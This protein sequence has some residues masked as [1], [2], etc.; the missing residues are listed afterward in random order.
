MK[1]YFLG[2]KA[3]YEKAM[4]DSLSASFTVAE[5]KEPSY[6]RRIYSLI[7]SV[8]KRIPIGMPLD[9]LGRRVND[10]L[11]DAPDDILI[12]N[13]WAL[14]RGVNTGIARTFK[15]RRVLLI[16]DL[17]ER[18][19]VDSVR[20]IFDSIYSF[21]PE[22]CRALDISHL[23][24]FFPFGEEAAHAMSGEAPHARSGAICN[25]LGRDKGRGS[26]LVEI[27][28]ALESQG[29]QLDFQ[30]VRDRTTQVESKYHVAKGRSYAQSLKM[31][32]AADVL[33]DVNQPGQ[34]GFTLRVLEAL[35]FDRKLLTTNGAV[36]QAPF[37]DPAR[38]FVWGE[39]SPQDLPRFLGGV[40]A[41]VS[42]D[43]LYR[44]S[45]EAMMRCV[46]SNL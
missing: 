40:P 13:A 14:P 27:A 44:H 18:S 17:S 12:C 32:F 21:D 39:D 43:T 16:R 22:Q 5:V 19:F 42:K 10:R 4:I 26:R 28:E 23:D 37:Y 36:K 9:W 29:C 3:D 34:A 8:R 45:P 1:I 38:F 33:V 6:V 31:S 20:D 24:Q 46:V 35:F 25:F 41:P 2:W 11:G 30:I 7:R 15:G